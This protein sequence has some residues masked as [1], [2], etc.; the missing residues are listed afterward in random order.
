MEVSSLALEIAGTDGEL[1][2]ATV[3]LREALE[4]APGEPEIRLLLARTL[5][6]RGKGAE[7]EMVAG[8]WKEWLGR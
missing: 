7:A 3:H 2:S 6:D 5:N 1:G 4:L 8:K